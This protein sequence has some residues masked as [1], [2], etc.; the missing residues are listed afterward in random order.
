MMGTFVEV[1]SVQPEAARIVFSEIGR[2]ERLLSKY[3]ESSE[4][5]QL[6]K[7]GALRVSPETFWLIKKCKEFYS[8]SGG[9]FD[10]TVGP[11]MDLWGFS[12]KK[13]R[14]P[15]QEEIKET[16]K[17]VGSD[18][19]ILHDSENVIEFKIHGLKLDMGGIAK[20]YALDCCV[21][22]L[23]ESKI[24]SCL[25]NL[26]GQVYAMGD[27][28]SGIKGFSEPWKIAIFQP[29]KKNF[30]RYIRPRDKSV[31]T[32]GNY[33][34]FFVQ[35]GRRFAHIFNPLTGYPAESGLSSVTIIAQDA[36]TA[37]FLSTAVFVLGKAKGEILLNKFPGV[38]DVIL[39]AKDVHQ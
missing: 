14:L 7:A 31:A 35:D 15:S 13:Y 28:P 25:V 36:L 29:D 4:I 22:K 5:Y 27:R 12:E 20:G 32:S 6:N 16:L 23:K 11:L 30:T 8:L 17:L 34:Q 38:G 3:K 2:I 18:K 21:K 24:T 33:E 9:A 26:G 19:I 1:V 39:E 37:D 10:I